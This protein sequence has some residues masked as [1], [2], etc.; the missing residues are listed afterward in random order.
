[1]KLNVAFAILASSFAKKSV[2][3]N[4]YDVHV[5]VSCTGVDFAALTAAEEDYAGTTLQYLFNYIH[6]R[7]SNGD[8]TLE[9]LHWAT[10]K[11]R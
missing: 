3:A 10:A 5:D 8:Y 11:A 2:M 6:T 4:N 9:N 1:M 7:F